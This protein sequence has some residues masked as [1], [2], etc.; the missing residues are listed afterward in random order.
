MTVAE[1]LSID[2]KMDDGIAITG[3]IH[4]TGLG[5]LGEMTGGYAWG[6]AQF[7]GCASP[8]YN[9]SNTSVTYALA[10]MMGIS[11]NDTK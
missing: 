11:S 8:D 2:T 7:N 5:G 3:N 4:S 10:I 6:S 9:V 1:A